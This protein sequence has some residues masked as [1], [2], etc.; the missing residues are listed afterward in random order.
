MGANI[1]NNE[2]EKSEK[3]MRGILNKMISLNKQNKKSW[4]KLKQEKE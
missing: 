1:L 4:I 2:P 3:E